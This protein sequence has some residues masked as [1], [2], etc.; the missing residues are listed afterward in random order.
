MTT[1]ET[2]ARLGHHGLLSKIGSAAWARYGR[3][4]TPGSSEARAIASLNHRTSARSTTSD[5]MTWCS[6][7]RRPGLRRPCHSGI[8]TCWCCCPRLRGRAV[9]IDPLAPHCSVDQPAR[10]FSADADP[11][12]ADPQP[13]TDLSLLREQC[14]AGR[15]HPRRRGLGRRGRRYD[16]VA[17][18]LRRRERPPATTARPGL[19]SISTRPRGRPSA[20][21]HRSC[22]APAG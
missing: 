3:A 11:P 8:S 20:R 2:G 1:W 18:A 15:R 7:A 16:I 13:L 19:S 9:V 4:A 12:D 6:R 14:G 5:P 10:Q 22:Q 17:K 21:S